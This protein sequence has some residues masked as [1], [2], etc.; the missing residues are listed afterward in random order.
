MQLCGVIRP[1]ELCD[2]ERLRVIERA[3][4]A[5]FRDIGMEAI[6]DDE[7]PSLD[8]LTAYQAV[9]RAWVASTSDADDGLPVAYVLV[10]VVDDAAHIE[11]LS[12]DPHFARR[13]LG[14]QLIDAVAGWAVQH[15]LHAVTLTTFTDVPWNAP[16]YARLGFDVVPDREAG[17][18]LTEVRLRERAH[19][20][21]AWP[22]QS[23]RRAV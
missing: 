14:R 3:A 16:Y 8:D 22:R 9:G 18:G 4:G 10:D 11:Q 20:L 15:G 13:G 2:L 7:P 5:A 1:A 6:A 12:V 21:D 17:P 19:G 23:M